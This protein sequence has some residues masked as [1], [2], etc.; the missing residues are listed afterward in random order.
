MFPAEF[1][2][3]PFELTGQ[4]VT[5]K[6]WAWTYRNSPPHVTPRIPWNTNGWDRGLSRDPLQIMY[7]RH[8][9]ANL[10]EKTV[11]Q[12]I[13]KLEDRFA[14]TGE[15][16]RNL[17][18]VEIDE[19]TCVAPNSILR[20]F[21]GT[22]ADISSVF[23]D[24]NFDNITGVVWEASQNPQTKSEFS[25]FLGNKTHITPDSVYTD[26]TRTE[27]FFGYP[28]PNI[29]SWQ[30][31]IG[32]R[33]FHHLVPR[34]EQIREELAP[35]V[36][37]A[38]INWAMFVA[39]AAVYGI[40]D[41]FLVGGSVIFIFIFMWFQT[42]S[43]F[44]TSFAVF[45]IITSFFGTNLIYRYALDFRYFGYFHLIAMFIILGIGADDIFVFFNTWKASAFENHRTTSI[46]LSEVYRR[47]AVSMFVTSFTT[48]VAFFVT[49][50]TPLIAARSFGIFTGILVIINY[51]SVVVF[52]PTVVYLYHLYFEN[53]DLC[54]SCGHSEKLACCRPKPSEQEDEMKKEPGVV[55][56]F[57]SGHYFEFIS[58][59]VGR[60]FLLLG[61]AV[62]F[63]FFAWSA[64]T[65]KSDSEQVGVSVNKLEYCMI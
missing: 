40:H 48:M 27:F 42:G 37:V 13:Q 6:Y 33:A 15:Y 24:T 7:S 60:W 53:K 58:H 55:V 62:V 31:Y 38:P 34:I 32:E 49:S 63:V 19:V 14:S 1:R 9:S 21:D 44:V 57:F 8:N 46:R 52:F 22:F 12:Q 26:Y 64:S 2:Q 41:I 11:L 35:D 61:F 25:Y 16:N 23:N 20:Y 47:A 4:A 36:K 54:I 39:G 30:G 43:F 17:C 28:I 10:F 45:S 18:Q 50:M 29:N 65:L 5:L 3:I 51:I 56:R 59:R